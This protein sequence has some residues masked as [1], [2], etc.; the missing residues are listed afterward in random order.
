MFQAPINLTTG[1][2]WDVYLL[3]QAG[4]E[5]GDSAPPRPTFFMHQLG[6]RLPD[7]SRLDGPKLRQAVRDMVEQ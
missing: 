7:A 3:Y 6:G 4:I 1:P 5:W 2:A